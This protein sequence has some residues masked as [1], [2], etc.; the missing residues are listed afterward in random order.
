MTVQRFDGQRDA[1]R[2]GV[3]DQWG[4]RGAQLR[5]GRPA[6]PVV[7]REQPARGGVQRAGDGGCG[8]RGRRVDAAA[9]VVLRCLDFCP[10]HPDEVVPRRHHCG[11]HR[12]QTQ[13]AQQVLGPFR[14]PVA[15]LFQW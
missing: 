9:E 6:L 7:Q 13:F 3:L 8:E 12:V 5:I 1:S 2:G 10:R 15:E 11:K 4:Q 14:I